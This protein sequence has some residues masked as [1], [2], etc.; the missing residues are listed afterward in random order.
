ME[1][2]TDHGDQQL[3]VDKMRVESEQSPRRTVL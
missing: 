3:R 1:V 2:V